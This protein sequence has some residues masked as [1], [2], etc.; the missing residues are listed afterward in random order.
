M[1]ALVYLCE[2]NGLLPGNITENI[3]TVYWK[4]VDNSNQYITSVAEIIVAGACSF[5][6]Y[7]YLRFTGSFNTI[8][9]VSITNTSG[10]IGSGLK[11]FTSRSASLSSDCY[12]YAKPLASISTIATNPLSIASSS[13]NLLVGT[14]VTSDPAAPTGKSTTACGGSGDVYSNYFISQLQTTWSASAGDIVPVVFT[15][16]Y[17]EN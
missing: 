17:D 12:P 14:D 5:E 3:F 1:A 2:R 13:I 10:L 9:N 16:S 11:V 7:N 4:A 6:K 15:L 8:T